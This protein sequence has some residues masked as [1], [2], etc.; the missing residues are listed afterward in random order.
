FEPRLPGNGFPHP[1]RRPMDPQPAFRRYSLMHQLLP[2]LEQENLWRRWDQ[3]DF[4]KNQ[5]DQNGVPW[6]PGWVFVRQ[7]VKPLVCPSNANAS[8]PMN[9]AVAPAESN[10]Y[11][12]TSYFGAAGT[13]GYPRWVIPPTPAT[14]PT[15]FDY[16]DGV[17]DQ[18]RQNRMADVTDGTTNTLMFG[19]RH[20]FDPVFDSNRVFNDRIGDWG[21]CWY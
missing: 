2:Y 9:T 16:R 11:F 10:R 17:F 21:W 4:A 15:L 7:I 20:Y 19:E 14:R 3:F 6:G 1:D 18:N 5:R 13:R 12:I 8:N